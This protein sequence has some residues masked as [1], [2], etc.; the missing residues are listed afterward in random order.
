MYANYDF[1]YVNFM[2]KSYTWDLSVVNFQIGKISAEANYMA[3][4]IRENL[5]VGKITHYM[6][7]VLIL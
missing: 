2:Q 3:F 5:D 1:I 7:V 6:V 4:A